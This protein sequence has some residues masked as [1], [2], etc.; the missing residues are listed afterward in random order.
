MVPSL[1]TDRR[2]ICA[3]MGGW[4][5]S[6]LSVES[7][8]DVRALKARIAKATL[9]TMKAMLVSVPPMRPAMP[10]IRNMAEAIRYITAAL[11]REL[12]SSSFSQPILLTSGARSR[13]N[14]RPSPPPIGAVMGGWFRG[15]SV[16]DGEDCIDELC[17]ALVAEGDMAGVFEDQVSCVEPVGFHRLR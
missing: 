5:G 6:Y 9:R 12:I 1:S 11:R 4:V 13:S 14:S 10:A 8:G 15:W 16:G 3:A 17:L 2:P 7:L